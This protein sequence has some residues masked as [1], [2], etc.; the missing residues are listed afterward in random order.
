[1]TRL[2]VWLRLPAGP[3]ILIGELIVSAPDARRGGRLRGEFRYLP[4]YLE[5]STAFPLDP[6]QLP[7]QAQSFAADRP[8]AGIHGV[9][10]DSLPDDWGRRILCRWHRLGRGQSLPANLL[11]L[12]GNQAMGALVYGPAQA[13]SSGPP[14]A[15]ALA[16]A[17]V[18]ATELS[19]LVDA[20]RRFEQSPPDQQS[21]DLMRLFQAASSP[22]GARPKVLVE[23]SD[24]GWLVKLASTRDRVDIVR[25][26]AASLRLAAAAGLDVAPQRLLDLHG[27]AALMLRRFDQTPGGGRRHVISLQTLLAADGYH[28]AG[29]SDLADILRRVSDRPELDLKALYRQ[30][31]FNA[32]LGN[33]DDHL[34][35]FAMLH[36]EDG[37]RLTPAYDLLP[38][39]EQRREHILHFGAGGLIPSAEAM[40]ALARAFGLSSKGALA[41]GDEVIEAVSR[42]REVFDAVGVPQG[43]S[44]SLAPSIMRRLERLG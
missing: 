32:A 2:T 12:I 41:I 19:A 43:D 1:M 22:G 37:W 36:D 10:E 26:E 3:P 23:D 11:A 7:L 25:I 38:D 39:V 44:D 31:L 15:P 40:V 4:E 33:T 18:P 34:K 24:G 14:P 29:Y 17:V 13:G 6:L 28:T 5:R 35:N 42:W 20:A 8:H 27:H 21:D 9:F 30:M 16:P